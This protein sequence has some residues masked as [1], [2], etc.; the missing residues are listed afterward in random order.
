MQRWPHPGN[1]NIRILRQIPLWIEETGPFDPANIPSPPDEPR[2]VAQALN[3]GTEKRSGYPA[4]CVRQQPV[5][6]PHRQPDSRRMRLAFRRLGK[7][8]LETVV[9]S[10]DLGRQPATIFF[11]L[12]EFR[13]TAFQLQVALV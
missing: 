5:P 7:V 1:G 6:A 13:R 10:R 8:M 2:D 4:G 11:K 9:Q 3:V 12:F